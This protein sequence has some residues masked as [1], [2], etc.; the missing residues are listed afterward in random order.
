MVAVEGQVLVLGHGFLDPVEKR[1]LERHRRIETSTLA[2]GLELREYA[3][4][5]GSV[6]SFDNGLPRIRH[7]GKTSAID[8]LAIL[9]D[10]A[11]EERTGQVSTS[12]LH[13]SCALHAISDGVH[14]GH[15]FRVQ[16]RVVE[17]S[18]FAEELVVGWTGTGDAL[19]SVEEP[20]DGG[21]R[22]VLGRIETALDGE[23]HGQIL[24]R[25][26]HFFGF[27][28]DQFQG[29]VPN[30]PSQVP[31]RRVGVV[32]Q[33]LGEVQDQTQLSQGR[34]VYLAQRVVDELRAE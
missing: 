12:S 18:E 30:D 16:I 32:H 15:E 10:E 21:S 4:R 9:G 14:A 2:E 22:L 17:V 19:S 26:H 6:L 7:A 11:S 34:L 5:S 31:A 33:L 8:G 13:R 20:L 3:I 23:G 1:R 29:K 25:G 24:G 28:V 27:G